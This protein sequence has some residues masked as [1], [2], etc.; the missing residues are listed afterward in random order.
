MMVHTP[1]KYT[2]CC[3]LFYQTKGRCIMLHIYTQY[4]QRK[5]ITYFILFSTPH[6][7]FVNL[8]ASRKYEEH[9]HVYHAYSVLLYLIKGI[10]AHLQ[11]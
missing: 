6:L 1:D 2:I 5:M 10:Y 3:I 7:T 9:T 8:V 4:Y 11:I